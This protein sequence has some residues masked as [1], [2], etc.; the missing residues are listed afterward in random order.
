MAT[1]QKLHIDRT[2]QLDIFSHASQPKVGNQPEITPCPSPR[3]FTAPDAET[4]YLGNSSLKSH[5]EMAGQK[6]PIIISQL[7]DEQNW[8][9]FEELY[10]K[11]GR[12]PYAPRAM[13]GLILYGIM[14]GVTSLRA[15]ERLAR[16]DLG[17]MWTSGGI[18]PDHANIGRFINR[19][20]EQL[21]G[22]F[23]EAMVLTVLKKTHSNSDRLAGDGTVIEAACSNYHLR[24]YAL[25]APAN[26]GSRWSLLFAK[27]SMN[28][29][30]VS[31]NSPRWC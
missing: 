31:L 1:K 6:T 16:L 28:L 9:T 21:T 15:L 11:S 3:R 4:I 18:F 24:T 25:M 10:G 7:L 30:T 5:L 13:V 14:Q 8:A 2:L 26:F 27:L 29:P 22:S 20:A 12:P 23:F 17:C 19:H